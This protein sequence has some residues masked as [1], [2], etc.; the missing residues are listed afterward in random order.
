MKT[1]RLLA[2]ALLTVTG[3]VGGCSSPAPTPSPT[4]EGIGSQQNGNYPPI[5]PEDKYFKPGPILATP[6]DAERVMRFEYHQK[7][8]DAYGFSYTISDNPIIHSEA[9]YLTGLKIP[10][11]TGKKKP[12]N[13][14]PK[15]MSLPVKWDWRTQGPGLPPARNQANC[16]SCWAFGTV[17]ALEGAIAAFD[18]QIVDLSEQFVLDCNNDGYSCGGGYWAYDLFKNPGAAWEKDNPYKAYDSSC[19]SSSIAHPYKIEEYHSVKSGDIDAMK[20]AIYQYGTIG[21]TMNVCGS[22][23][24][25][26]G[27]IYDSNECNNSAS[28]HIVALVGW[29]DTQQTKKGKGV[30]VLRNS[31]GASWGDKGYGLFAYGTAGLEDDPTYVVYK[32]VDN[33]DTD[34]DTVPDYRDNCKTVPNTDQLDADEDGA[35]D[36]C[37]PTFDA[38]EHAMTLTDDD[39]RKV[40]IGF[41][42]PF[43]GTAYTEVSVNSDG[44]LTFGVEDNKSGDRSKGRFL[45][46]APRIAALYADLNPAAGG[47][48][49]YGKTE[50]SSLFVK[51]EGVPLY[52]GGSAGTIMVTLR[53]SG[54]ITLNYSN[55]PASS[56][57]V[58]VSKGGANNTGSEIDLSN[59]GNEIPYGSSTALFEQYGSGKNFD[60][61]GKTLTF[62]T[63][64]E[65][66]VEPDAGP[67]PDA[68][69]PPPP[70]PV[71]VQISLG[72]DDTKSIPI[73]FSFPYYGKS[74]NTVYVNSD[75]NLT[76]GVGDGETAE[77]STQRL[78]TGAPRIAVLFGD[79]NPAAGG[80]VSYR[81][82]DAQTLTIKYA[83]VPFYGTAVGNTATVKLQANGLIT[84]TYGG[85]S[86]SS[87][88]VGVS[89]GGSSNTS[90]PVDLSTSGP[91]LAYGGTNAV[92]EAFGKTRPFDLSGKTIMFSAD[93][94][95]GPGPGPDGGGPVA[96]VPLTMADDDTKSVPLG[97]KF[98]FYGQTY[99]SVYVN[100]DGNLSFGAGD[101]ASGVDR[102]I[103]RFLSGVPRIAAVYADLNPAA[104]GTVSYRQDDAQT[105]TITYNGVPNY[106]SKVGNTF[107]IIL[108]ASGRIAIAIANVG[109]TGY[110]VGVSE[111][112]TDNAGDPTDLTAFDG[113]TINYTGTGAVYEGFASQAFDLVGKTV[114][115]EP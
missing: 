111:G 104:G 49:S 63:S 81:Q 35:G 101:G 27:G 14:T 45:T 82:D 22:I 28:N 55:V 48:V 109:G 15:P 26:S 115:F 71:D 47:K 42:F 40:A 99:T 29:D 44:N 78:L 66:P 37:D 18:K 5:N 102:S 83:N 23:P 103:A 56:Y 41:P 84:I 17:A 57:I 107:S 32:P 2:L 38:F 61:A 31:W 110:I 92:F 112:G 93:V 21:V 13:G 108:K 98:P 73:G 74:Y 12:M 43:Y 8:I 106:G 96:D 25:Y 7:V 88:I 87:Y 46:F 10:D 39:G 94:G 91:Q 90:N 79:L 69:P 52:K 24:G 62:T 33:T 75:G 68:G 36:A 77:R 60:L 59:A 19:K 100:A 1:L 70:T 30:W 50:K 72:D 3:S 64:T 67:T 58:G 11:D 9:M 6:D 114:V 85:V 20:S 53:D 51:Y 54:R 76:F 97:F 4:P 86:G 95:P 16:G 65:P 113:Q 105:M 80:T 34:K 89:K